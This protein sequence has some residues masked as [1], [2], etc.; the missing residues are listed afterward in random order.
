MDL[1]SIE[2]HEQTVLVHL[3]ATSLTARCPRC[4]TA[5][6][7]VHSRY[8][9]T[10]VDLAF[11]GRNL[12]LTLLVRKWI[13]PEALC[14]QHIFAERFP[15]VVQRY[16]RMTDRLIKAL[17]SAGVITNGADA[18]QI[19]ESFGVPTTAKTIIRRVLQLPLPSEGEVAKVGIDEWAWKKGQCYGT[20][21][22]E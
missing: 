10:I 12:T 22:V 16:A 17:Q 13:C 14:S 6:S 1:D 3:H 2:V 4:G 5:G 7:R 15:E 18:A 11:G 19:A 9:R 20:I 8:Q 21:L